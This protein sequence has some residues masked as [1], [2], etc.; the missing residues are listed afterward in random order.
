MDIQ[1]FI[2]HMPQPNKTTSAEIVPSAAHSTAQEIG[3]DTNRTQT[4]DR[5]PRAA[6]TVATIIAN[7]R[8]ANSV[9]G[10][11]RALEFLQGH[12]L[13]LPI[14]FAVAE[15]SEYTSW[16]VMRGGNVAQ[17]SS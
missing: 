11:H 4:I 6:S 7:V 15:C 14:M 16:T 9:P 3:G 17:T 10:D 12:T 8:G 5:I 1:C 13:L 2:E